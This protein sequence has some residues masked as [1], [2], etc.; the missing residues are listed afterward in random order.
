LESYDCGCGTDSSGAVFSFSQ[1]LWAYC[2][3]ALWPCGCRH[4]RVDHGAILMHLLPFSSPMMIPVQVLEV[5]SDD[6]NVPWRDAG[7]HSDFRQICSAYDKAV[8]LP[9]ELQTR[10]PGFA[11]LHLDAVSW[12]SRVHSVGC[13]HRFSFQTQLIHLDRHHS[14][15]RAYFTA[16]PSLRCLYPPCCV[17]FA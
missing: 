12:S 16:H 10:L 5:L 7:L 11:I 8:L 2:L 6:T 3:V 15:H 14:F 13:L 4:S 1:R 17:R 9:F